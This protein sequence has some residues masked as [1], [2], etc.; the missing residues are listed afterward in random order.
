MEH[1]ERAGIH[2]GDS[3][4]VYPTQ[5][6]NEKVKETIIDYGTRIGEGFEFVGLYNIQ[7][8]VDKENNVYVLEVNPR[9]SRTVPF[10]SKITGV[11]MSQIATKCVLGESIEE[12]G[13]TPGYHPED[14]E[15]VFVK[16][17]VFSFAK[18]RSV[19]TVLGP[20]MKSTGEAL[21]SDV[22]LE[23]HCTKL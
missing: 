13:L 23:K 16:A 3:I 6:I 14:K 18:L 20:E 15:R 17:P 12:Q 22:N 9:S 1:I 8:I 2:S 4:S 10:L 7:F 19:D 21:G 11:A 5:I